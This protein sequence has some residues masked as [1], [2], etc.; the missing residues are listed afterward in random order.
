LNKTNFNTIPAG[1][2]GTAGGHPETTTIEGEM[3]AKLLADDS[4]FADKDFD[5]IDFLRSL[6]FGRV[7]RKG[8]IV[9]GKLERSGE[10]LSI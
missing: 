6:K 5:D 1:A 7:V 8:E 9:K 3:L 4:D 2:P 10:D